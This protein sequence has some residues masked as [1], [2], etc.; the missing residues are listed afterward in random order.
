METEE[1][2]EK[3]VTI[4]DGTNLVLGRLASNISKKLLLGE[5]VKILNCKNIVILGRK[6]F[7]IEKYKTK[8][9]NKVVK[10][11]PYYSRSPA[12]IVK[13]S[14]RNMVPYKN[15]RGVDA[16]KRLKCYN[17]IPSILKNNETITVEKAKMSNE[18]FYY[19]RIETLCLTL[20]YKI[21]K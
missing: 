18:S 20:G 8:L 4:I 21:K 11:G 12:D 7:L 16:L 10:Q 13:R 1:K 5:E 3:N 2:Q 15:K 17:S 6:K 19:T 14:F 9:S